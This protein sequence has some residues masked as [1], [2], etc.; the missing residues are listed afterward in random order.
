MKEVYLRW[1]AFETQKPVVPFPMSS[2][3]L[4]YAGKAV[5]PSLLRQDHACLSA[6]RLPVMMT[7]DWYGL[8]LINVLVFSL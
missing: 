5:S 6:A 1:W 3:C 7:M 2:L 4:Q 8:A